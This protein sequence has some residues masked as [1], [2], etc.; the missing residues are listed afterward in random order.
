ME[1]TRFQTEVKVLENQGTLVQ[2]ILPVCPAVWRLNEIWLGT[3]L[4]AAQGHLETFQ[5][6][7]VP[8]DFG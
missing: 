2:I 7:T 5:A 6:L 1:V 3:G 4:I 8:R